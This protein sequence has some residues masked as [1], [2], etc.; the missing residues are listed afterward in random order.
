[1]P[2]A[3]YIHEHKAVIKLGYRDRSKLSVDA[4]KEAVADYKKE[5]PEATEFE[6]YVAL[7]YEEFERI[8]EE[9]RRAL[10]YREEYIQ[11]LRSTI[12]GLRGLV[13]GLQ[14]KEIR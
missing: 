9:Q 13:N 7:D 10:A 11:R 2:N 1:M 3:A 4:R 12:E 14:A 6:T 5:H 8:I